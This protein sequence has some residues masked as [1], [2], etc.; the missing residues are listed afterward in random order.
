MADQDTQEQTKPLM[1]VVPMVLPTRWNNGKT[2]AVEDAI[3]NA[4]HGIE[5]NTLFF[6]KSGATMTVRVVSSEPEEKVRKEILDVLDLLAI[7]H[8]GLKIQKS[9]VRVEEI[10]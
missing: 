3:K 8:P 2:T 4:G 1:L 10:S 5:P 6:M 7:G 9:A